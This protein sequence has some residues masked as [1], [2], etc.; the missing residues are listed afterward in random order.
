MNNKVITVMQDEFFNIVDELQVHSNLAFESLKSEF[1]KDKLDESLIASMCE[2]YSGCRKVREY[3]LEVMAM[4]V[5]VPEGAKVPENAIVV[6]DQDYLTVTN[7]LIGLL[8]I[9]RDI[10]GK[11]ISLSLH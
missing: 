10:L 5:T 9:Q 1:S 4:E 11:N 3:V 2:F 7:L 8:V 6:Q